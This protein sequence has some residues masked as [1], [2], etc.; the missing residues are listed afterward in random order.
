MFDE[1]MHCT[2]LVKLNLQFND[3]T[4]TDWNTNSCWLCTSM[5]FPPPSLTVYLF[6]HALSVGSFEI[7]H[8]FCFLYLFLSIPLFLSLAI[9]LFLFLVMVR[10]FCEAD[11]TW[12]P[13][14]S[15]APFVL[16]IWQASPRIVLGYQCS[17]ADRVTA[18]VRLWPISGFTFK[19][20]SYHYLRDK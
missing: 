8:L 20:D 4:T 17:P 6:Q 18:C 3:C 1:L 16:F 2:L 15:S 13:F 10:L 12:A 5:M 11:A 14:Y 7:S 9:T 19:S